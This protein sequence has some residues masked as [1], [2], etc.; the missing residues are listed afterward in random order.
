M[1]L[2]LVECWWDRQNQQYVEF[3]SEFVKLADSD[4]FTFRRLDYP[5]AYQFTRESLEL[6]NRCGDRHVLLTTSPVPDRAHVLGR[7]RHRRKYLLESGIAGCSR[8]DRGR[9]AL[10]RLLPVVRERDADEAAGGLG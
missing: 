1:T 10:D 8:Q 2:G 6:L 3:N 4:R 7:R 5:E 9:S